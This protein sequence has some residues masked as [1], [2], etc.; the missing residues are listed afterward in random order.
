MNILLIVNDTLRADHLGC[1]GYFRKTSPN[2]DELAKHGITFEEFYASG[3]CTGTSFTGIHTGLY[4]IHHGVYNVTPPDLMLDD[5]PT[6]A[7]ILRAQGYT[8]VAFDNLAHNRSWSQDPVHYYRGFENYVSDISNPNDW[9]DLGERVRAD[10]YNDRLIPWLATHR[11]DK[12]FAFVHYW[13]VHQPY[14]Q[15]ESYRSL[16]Q[17][18]KGDLSDLEIRDAAAGYRYVPGWGQVDELYEG[19]GVVPEQRSPGTVPSRE[20]SVDLY[21]GAVTYVDHCIGEVLGQLKK[22]GLL[23]DTL[24]IVTSDHGELLGQ[25]GIY[26]HV[27]LYDANIHV[28]LIISCPGQLDQGKR[29]KG[30]ASQVDLLPTIL[31]LAGV[32]NTAQVDG[33]SLRTLIDGENIREEV[34]SE[35]G[36]GI[37]A[38]RVGDWKLIFYCQ[39]AEVELYNVARDPMEIVNLAQQE[40]DKVKELMRKLHLWVESNLKQGVEDPMEYVRR[41]TNFREDYQKLFMERYRGKGFVHG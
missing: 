30:F 34:I 1:Y 13:D 32:A 27:N 14:T 12:F 6:L 36:G 8:T 31:D 29:V 37:R 9:N 4:P 19:Y 22:T 11:Q 35:D 41:N 40:E 17:H 21:D 33:V 18:K 5:T 20:A 38:I 7:E 39:D 23:Q 16:F 26:T 2:M 25:H 3:V 28:P 24:V 10:W 15:P